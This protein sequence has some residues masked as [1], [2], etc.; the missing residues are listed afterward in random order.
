MK[1][2]TAKTLLKAYEDEGVTGVFKVCEP[3]KLPIRYCESCECE[4]PQWGRVCAACWES[5]SDE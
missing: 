2:L 5:L 4:V 1:P 3:H